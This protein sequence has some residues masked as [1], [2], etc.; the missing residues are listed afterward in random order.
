[1]YDQDGLGFPEATERT[2][3]QKLQ[4]AAE[5][6]REDVALKRADWFECQ[7]SV[8]AERLVFL[9]ET[10]LKTNFTRLRGWAF[11]GEDLSNLFPLGA[12]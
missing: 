6:D 10:G 8:D 4:P 2:L 12:G 7:A 9:D 5:Q 3:S 1:M 11:G